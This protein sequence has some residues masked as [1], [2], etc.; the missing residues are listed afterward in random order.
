MH[1]RSVQ[2]IHVFQCMCTMPILA[3]LYRN[4]MTLVYNVLK[5]MMQINSKLFE[6]LTNAF[7][8][9]KQQRY[10]VEPLHCFGQIK[11]S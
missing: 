1:I 2:Y 7:K 5:V 8:T 10:R 9:E 11:V 4:I 6:E 3:L